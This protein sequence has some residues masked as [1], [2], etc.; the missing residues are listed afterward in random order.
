MITLTILGFGGWLSNPYY[1][2]SGY[3][4][5]TEELNIL[6]DAGEGTYRS[7][8]KC[9]GLSAK[10]L[11]YVVLTHSHGDHVL[12]IPTMLQMAL[13]EGTK[14]RILATEDTIASVKNIMN[15]LKVP[16]FL[17]SAEFMELPYEGRVKL[18]NLV[19][20]VFRAIHPPPSISVILELNNTRIAYSGDT[21]PNK[22]FLKAAAG[23]NILIHEVSAAEDNAQE[24]LK[25]GH[26]S[27]L[28]LENIIL[29]ARPKLFLPTHYSVT[30]PPIRCD[31]RFTKC[32]T[33]S[34]CGKY[35][36]DH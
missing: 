12:G 6:L 15:S 8:R 14:I 11:N 27:T 10:D 23:S 21:S 25:Y 36:I 22:N 35:I 13:Y 20:R 29:T 26:T 30:P 2:Q 28:D 31:F 1:G 32:L 3:L 7:L 9:E 33:P 34:V 18:N 4:I 17:S 16:N 24:A 19:I 5:R